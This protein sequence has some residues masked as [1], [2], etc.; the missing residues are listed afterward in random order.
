MGE[1]TQTIAPNVTVEIGFPPLPVAEVPPCGAYPLCNRTGDIPRLLS[2]IFGNEQEILTERIW[3]MA[4]MN[5]MKNFFSTFSHLLPAF[6]P[7]ET[8]AYS[9]VA[10]QI[11]SYALETITGRD[12]QTSL[13]D[14]LL[15]PL[16]LAHTFYKTPSESVGVIP[17]NASSTGWANNLGEESRECLKC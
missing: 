9:N 8:P 5:L 4:D 10:F 17:G 13:Q 1:I 6:A 14:K 7:G 11:L 15:S 12:Y 16:N 3:E 2:T